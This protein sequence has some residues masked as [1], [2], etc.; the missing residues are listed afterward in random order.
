MLSVLVQMTEEEG[1]HWNGGSAEPMEQAVPWKPGSKAGTCLQVSLGWVSEPLAGH[2]HAE[3]KDTFKPIPAS[4]EV[5]ARRLD[6]GEM[7][8]EGK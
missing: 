8:G 5:S 3:W 4:G 7:L 2:S 1:G 6:C